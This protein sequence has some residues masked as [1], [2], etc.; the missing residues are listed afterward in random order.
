MR[1]VYSLL[2][3]AV[4]LSSSLAINANADDAT[5]DHAKPHEHLDWCNRQIYLIRDF[6]PKMVQE[7]LLKLHAQ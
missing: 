7:K 5:S 4:I 3:L 2:T 6:S 1:K